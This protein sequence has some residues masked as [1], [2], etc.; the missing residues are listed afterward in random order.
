MTL[1]CSF[2]EP[3][4]TDPKAR[5][6]CVIYVHG[7]SGSRMD[8]IDCV[9]VLLPNNICLFSFDCSGS[10]FSEGTYVSLGYHEKFDVRAIIEYLRKSRNISRI[11]IWGRSMGAVTALMYCGQVAPSPINYNAYDRTSQLSTNEDDDGDSGVEMENGAQVVGI[12]CDSPFCSLPLLAQEFVEL[13][14]LKIPR[15]VVSLALKMI[16]RTIE[17]KAHF[18]IEALKPI[19]VIDKCRIPAVFA[20]GAEDALISPHH[21]VDLYEKYPGEKDLLVFPGGHNSVRPPSFYNAVSMFFY[22]VLLLNFEESDVHI[23]IPPLVFRPR[24]N[25]DFFL[26][27][28]GIIIQPEFENDDAELVLSH[29]QDG[30]DPTR[31]RDERSSPAPQHQHQHQ[32]SEQQN[33]EQSE[34]EKR[35]EEKPM[36]LKEETEV[37][38]TNKDI[39]AAFFEEDKD[40]KACFYENVSLVVVTISTFGIRVHKPFTEE[41]VNSYP[42]ENVHSWKDKDESFIVRY[43][44]PEDQIAYLIFFSN[45][46]SFMSA[47][48]SKYVRRRLEEQQKGL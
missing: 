15:F 17:Q 7:N 29:S 36:P 4:R 13:Q 45:R 8:A 27:K 1:Q 43:Q 39:R 47:A 40:E 25:T 19:D 21:S 44:L 2:Y 28:R 20:H 5:L 16:A 3:E 10:G 42:L 31:I 23:P 46:G 37:T 22:R 26:C 9:P 35:I 18:H 48:M 33:K 41:L 11:G 12:V 32:H 34:S 14:K 38:R 24:P 30:E 6:P